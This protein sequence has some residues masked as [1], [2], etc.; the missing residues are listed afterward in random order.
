VPGKLTQ[1]HSNFSIESLY[2]NK[3]IVSFL[4]Q[5]AMSIVSDTTDTHPSSL[6]DIGVWQIGLEQGS[7]IHGL[8]VLF[9]IEIETKI[10]CS[11][12]IA[13]DMQM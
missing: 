10:E 8:L 1:V 9:C 5:I 11:V 13:H 12:L 4:Q 6:V 7:C 2:I 3:T